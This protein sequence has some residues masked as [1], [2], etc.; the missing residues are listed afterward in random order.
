LGNCKAERRG[1][2]WHDGGR[3]S[4]VVYRPS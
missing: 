2:E 3:G 1:C 4:F